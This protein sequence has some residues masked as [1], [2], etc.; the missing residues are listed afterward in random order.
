MSPTNE[1][2]VVFG[3]KLIDH[4]PAKGVGNATFVVFPIGLGV[5]G[6]GPEEVVEETIVRDVGWSGDSA[7]VVHVG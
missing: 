2:K 1:I 4:V 5:A 3:E 6:I 7:D